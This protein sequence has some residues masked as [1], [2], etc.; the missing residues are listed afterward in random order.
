L[1]IPY[2]QIDAFT[3]QLF[4]G[5]PAGVCILEKWLPDEILQKIAFENNLAETAFFV[6]EKDHFRLRWFTPI[7]EM[8]LCGHA[9][10]AAAHTIYEFHSYSKNEI[11][12][13]TKSGRLSV[14]RENGNLV[15]DFPS[16]VPQVCD[17][18]AELTKSFGKKPKEVFGSRDYV[19][20]FES[21]DEIRAIKPDF[22]SLQKL[23]RFGV[24]ITAPGKKV[25]F[26][27]RFFAP[28]AGI[29]EDPVTGSAHCS[30]IPFWSQRLS[31]KKLHAL[32]L[33]QRGGELFCEDLGER[34]KIGG[35]AVTYL[36]GEIQTG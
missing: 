10:L 17:V 14:T 19:A 15:L 24:I 35:K 25:D 31:K 13:E 28:K 9:T 29:P 2:F 5:N 3:N 20:V 21:E 32:Q 7:L 30:L 36:R 18:P 11:H 4:S 33:S 12:F 6:P 26:V 1:K 8:D 23:E 34:V 22:S 16:R 27:S